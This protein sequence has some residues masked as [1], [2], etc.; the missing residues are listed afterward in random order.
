MNQEKCFKKISFAGMAESVYA[1]DLKSNEG[2]FVRVRV[3]LPA[4]KQQNFLKR[5]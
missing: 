5:D 1:L 4:P 3:P 2:N